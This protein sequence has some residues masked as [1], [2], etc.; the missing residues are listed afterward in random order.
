VRQL[1]K[2]IGIVGYWGFGRGQAYLNLCHAKMLADEYDVFI[3]KI[4]KNPIAEE[5]KSVNICSITEWPNWDIDTEVFK[6][7]II[8]NS[9]DAVIFN[10]YNQWGYDKKDLNQIARN[11]G[12][13][14]YAWLALER[15]LP[16]QASAYDRL[17]ASTVSYQ[18]FF[19][20]LKIRNFTYIPFSIDFKEF[21][22]VTR[23]QNEKFTF[24][25][26]SGFGGVQDR[27]NT[28]EV[29]KAFKL[30]N[31][32]NTRLIITTQK[33]QMPRFLETPIDNIE[34]IVKD[35]TRE[36]M[37]KLY[38]EADV[39][40]MPTKWESIGIPILE[41]LASGTPVITTDAHPMNEF[42]KNN[43]NGLV[44]KGEPTRYDG[45][46]LQGYDVDALEIKSK[47]EI[48]MNPIIWGILAKNSRKVAEDF[49]DLEKNKK[50]FLEFLKKD[51]GE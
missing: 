15:F 19:R 34:V 42:I 50:Y 1:K 48:I 12:I 3:F 43:I 39:T 37:L 27:K 35:L 18:R 16:E 21:P 45:I 30:L 29:F 36:E 4:F 10:E 25:H 14:T 47:M 28:E 49:Y 22:K 8:E 9:L 13:R 41:S 26:P 17:I 46:T 33:S 2:G 5:F 40:V 51:L 24:F 11:L 7:W 38:R 23:N 32:P 44:C 20:S 6:E 31:N